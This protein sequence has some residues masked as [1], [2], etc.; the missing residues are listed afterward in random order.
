MIKLVKPSIK[1]KDSFIE[2][3]NE[4]HNEGKYND[5]YNL[6]IICNDFN[7]FLSSYDDEEKG[8]NLAEGYVPATNLWLVDDNK[9][10]GRVSIRHKL[11]K[12]LLNE[13]GHIGY[14]VRPSERK[15]GYGNKILELSLPIARKIGIDKALLICDDDN[16]GSYKIIE[17]N[18]G[19]LENKVKAGN[20]LM[21]RYWI[22][23][24]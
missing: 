24:D 1:Y 9:F 21:R 6:E 5:Y 19:I 15:K 22:N 23:L 13:G 7:K 11:T 10:L 3:V 16:I 20:R 14:G 12:K 8:I 17:K 4:F 2:S 18:G